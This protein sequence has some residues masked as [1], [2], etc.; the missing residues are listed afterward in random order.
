[1]GP[2]AQ[3]PPPYAPDNP[4]S[5]ASAPAQKPLA[6]EEFNPY[7]A[8]AMHQKTIAATGGGVLT[9]HI[10]DM[11]DVLSGTWRVLNENLGQ[12]ALAG[13]V[14]FAVVIGVSFGGGMLG[15]IVQA[16]G[17]DAIG[18]LIAVQ[19]INQTISFLVQTWIW[20]GMA[21]W[22]LKMMRTRQAGVNEL[23]AVGPY[24]LRGLGGGLLIY[25]IVLGAGAV[26]VG[27]PVLIAW[28]TGSQEAMLIAGGVGGMVWL[29]VAMYVFFTYC[30]YTLFIIDRNASV[31]E[32]FRL[33]AE[34]TRGNRISIFAILLLIGMAG[35]L[36][37]VCTCYLGFIIYIPYMTLVFAMMYLMA[38]GQYYTGQPPLLK[39][40]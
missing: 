32:A 30:L 38:T 9:H 26:L 8:P 19:V 36:F 14:Y 35:G 16:A 23:F 22:S 25:L 10:L 11:G 1:V 34:F 24:Y 13:L 4:F 15:G 17:G 6:G 28:S 12:C 40:I 29:V 20:L 21:A 3:E 5:D 18:V 31:L 2:V 39:Q 27:I 33:S 37:S 7:A